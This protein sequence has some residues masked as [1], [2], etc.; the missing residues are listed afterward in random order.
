MTAGL[1]DNVA[2][3]LAKAKSGEISAFDIEAAAL[4]PLP[5]KLSPEELYLLVCFVRHE[6]RQKWVGFIVESRLRGQGADLAHLGAFAHPE[7]IP[8]SGEVP[9][10]EGWRYFF[11]G[12]GCCFTNTDG[13]SID[14]DFADDGTALEID[15]YFFTH[16]LQSIPA[17]EWHERQLKQP[18]GFEN[19]W[20]FELRRLAQKNLIHRE[21]RFRLTDDGRRLGEFLEPLAELLDSAAPAVRCWLLCKLGDFANA[22]HEAKANG[23]PA[24]P[25]KLMQ[26]QRD[27]RLARLKIVIRSSDEAQAQVALSALG[28][29]GPEF[30]LPELEL[31]VAR[32]PASG[33]NHTAL[34]VLKHWNTM[35]VT[36]C[37][38][39]TLEAMV[40]VPPRSLLRW[41]VPT[42]RPTEQDRPRH[43]LVV[44][45]AEE[46]MRRFSPRD[47]PQPV[48][49]LL[50]SALQADCFAME[51]VGGFLLFLL[52][53]NLGLSKL[54]KSLDSTVP[55][56]RSGAAGFLALIGSGECMEILIR[57]ASQSPEQG[58]HEA[59][60]ALS[61]FDD[62]RALAA[63]SE[64]LRR[65]DG[66][67]EAEGQETELLGRKIR[68]W[69]FEEIRRSSLREEMRWSQERMRKRFGPLLVTWQ[70]S[71][72]KPSH[73]RKP[74]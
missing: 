64:W 24:P 70:H 14:V 71:L 57:S 3:A 18:D 6:R 66:Y 54:A 8:Q 49:K 19:A 33:L 5:T 55:M 50:V 68:T 34:A 43:G 61:L 25:V 27:E 58:G 51:D 28:L 30:A 36:E 48:R 56:A 29:M 31:A 15:P 41:F 52:E 63:T 1:P 46:L 4:S 47:L 62:E 72:M 73:S 69:S 7:E 10:E 38:N 39:S 35:A 11:H 16:Y 65:N 53:P 74:S 2:I 42:N 32:K 44:G 37:L 67:E 45:I 40:E 60:C 23:I 21:W 22:T 17:A 12:R 59:A 13:T 9:G 20:Q 26:E